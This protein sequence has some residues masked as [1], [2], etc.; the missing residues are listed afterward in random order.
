MIT[1][2]HKDTAVAI[3]GTLGIVDDDHPNAITGPELDGMT[4]EE[5]RL[6]VQNYNVF[7]RSSPQNKIMIVKALQYSG[8]VC[9]MTGDRVNDAPALKAAD[10]GVAMGKEST[11][12]ARAASDVRQ[13]CVV[14]E[15][16][17]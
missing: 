16:R 11:D 17:M 15:F 1:G 6:E 5:L 14:R 2:D 3:G 4:D 9:C 8:E 10:V 13:C 12:Y 7:A